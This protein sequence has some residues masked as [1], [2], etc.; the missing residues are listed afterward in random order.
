MQYLELSPSELSVNPPALVAGLKMDLSLSAVWEGKSPK[1][2]NFGVSPKTELLA[3]FIF[4][5][6][7]TLATLVETVSAP[8]APLKKDVEC[9]FT[10]K[11]PLM[12]ASNG[13]AFLLLLVVLG[14]LGLKVYWFPICVG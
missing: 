9:S 11:N 14:L 4:L 3:K 5:R 10:A 6:G 8:L 1:S 2:T 12:K 7:L 13:S